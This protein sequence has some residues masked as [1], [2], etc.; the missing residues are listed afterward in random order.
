MEKLN[1]LFKYFV[2]LAPGVLFFSYQP[3]M[4]FGSDSSMNFE[5]S[6][7]LVWLIL[8]DLL[9]FVMMIK[10]KVLF[11][12]FGK[13]WVWLLFPVWLLLSV[14]WSL[15]IVRG[16]L[17][18]GVLW[19]LYFAVYGIWRFRN[20]FDKEFWYVFW[21]WFFGASLVVCGWCVVQCILDLCGVGREYTLMC[22]GCTYSMFG[23]PHPNG[24]A[25]EPQFMGNLL[26][27]PT[28]VAAWLIICKKNRSDI[29]QTHVQ[30]PC[31]HRGFG[32]N[33]RLARLRN[34]FKTS[35]PVLFAVFSATLFL[36]FSR[37]AI[38]AFIVGLLVMSVWVVVRERKKWKDVLKRVGIVWGVV[39]LSFV[40]CLNVQG[41]MAEFGP[42]DDTYKSGI[43]KVINHLSLGAIN[44]D[45]SPVTD[46]KLEDNR[47]EPVE[48]I[49]ENSEEKTEIEQAVYDGY[50][51]ESTD[52]RLRLSGAAVEVWSKDF[53]NAMFGVGIGGAGQALYVN[54]LSPAPKEI[55]Q[56]QYAS[57]L[58]ETG[59]VGISLLVL[60]IV[61]AVKVVLRYDSKV[62]MISLMV[63]YAISLC[64]FSGLPNA[65]HIY[66]LPAILLF[67]RCL[68]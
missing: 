33:S 17:T 36:T 7:P 18:V 23:F 56:N 67:V 49:V 52:T 50:V 48:N 46:E 21:K 22:A 13:W 31:R 37:G 43:S 24:F 29:F 68:W 57:L 10:K 12:D 63:A 59:L 16:L 47:E 6:V 45:D 27:A 40:V 26:L 2:Y 51:A 54:N 9:V 44:V 14:F 66:L 20:L 39:V 41:L 15:N 38:Y 35:L 60:T 1:K 8:F 42:T 55:V 62:M 34:V 65:L 19:L 28:L 64:F 4:H 61:F 53:T 3:L 32:A 25:I 11:R 30:N 58:L 5:L